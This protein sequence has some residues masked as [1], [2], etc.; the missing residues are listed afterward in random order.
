MSL[1]GYNPIKL[2]N[3]RGAFEAM[4]AGL[5]MIP[6]YDIAFKCNFA[7]LNEETQI[8]ENR[9]VDRQFGDWGTSLCDVLD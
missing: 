8:V 9:R 5:L 7:Y 3:G 6:D 4:G 2:Y 1:F